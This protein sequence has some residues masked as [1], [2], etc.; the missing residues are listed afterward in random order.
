MFCNLLDNYLCF[1]FFCSLYSALSC[2]LQ[3]IYTKWTLKAFLTNSNYHMRM[4]MEGHFTHCEHIRSAL[5]KTTS[6]WWPGQG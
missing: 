6:S 5:A 3:A 4:Q 1:L 2:I